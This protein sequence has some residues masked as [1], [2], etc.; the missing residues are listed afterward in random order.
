MSSAPLCSLRLARGEAEEC[1]GP[2]CPF[3]D[4]AGCV[5]EPVDHELTRSPEVASHLLELRRSLE[6]A[7]AAEGVVRARSLFS[8]RL[9]EEQAAEA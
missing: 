3:W 8:R 5:L 6:D 1:P 9:N 4:G 2:P 7:A